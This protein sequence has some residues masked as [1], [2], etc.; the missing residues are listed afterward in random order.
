MVGSGVAA[1]PHQR[2]LPLGAAFALLIPGKDLLA[3]S[4]FPPT[5][6]AQTSR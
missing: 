2:R 1:P 3:R 4:S 6:T 5:R